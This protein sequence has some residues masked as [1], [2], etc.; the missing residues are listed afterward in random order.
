MNVNYGRKAEKEDRNEMKKGQRDFY[1][2]IELQHL[3]NKIIFICVPVEHYGH[4]NPCHNE[5]E[6]LS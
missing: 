4:H 2:V 6:L 1:I 5:I 3:L